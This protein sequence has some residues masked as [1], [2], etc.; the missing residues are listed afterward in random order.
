[1]AADLEGALGDEVLDEVVRASAALP[2]IAVLCEQAYNVRMYRW[3]TCRQLGAQLLCPLLPFS[4][5]D[6]GSSPRIH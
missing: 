2:G 3:R 1:M 6:P 5:L 4:I